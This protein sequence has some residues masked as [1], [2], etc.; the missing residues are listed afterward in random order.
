MYSRLLV[1]FTGDDV[2]CVS[3][4]GR[5]SLSS[6]SRVDCD[7]KSNALFEKI[8]QEILASQ[9]K[10]VLVANVIVLASIVGC[11]DKKF[12]I[13]NT[14]NTTRDGAF[15]FHMCIPCDKTF[16]IVP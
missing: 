7:Q 5:I 2:V 12:S 10:Y 9:D 15:I 3:D 11:V 8:Y 14:L 16:H 1:R 4:Q 13:G 6:W